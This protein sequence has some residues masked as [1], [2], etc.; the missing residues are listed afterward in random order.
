MDL[1]ATKARFTPRMKARQ[2]AFTLIELLVVIAIIAILAA[3]LLPVLEKAK[4]RAL[5]SQCLNNMKQLQVCYLMYVQDNNDWLPPNVSTSQQSTSTNSGSW[6]GGD[7]QTDVTIKNIQV[8]VLY[9]YN[10]SVVMYAC[11]ANTKKITVTGLGNIGPDGHPLNPGS[12]VPQTRTCSIDFLLN[13]MSGTPP[14]T[15]GTPL[16][17]NG[18]SVKPVTKY[19]GLATCGVSV[20][21]KIVFVDESEN[22]VG[23]GCFG[24]NV[25][26]SGLDSWW[27]LPGS[28]HTKGSTFAFA[29][30]HVEYWKWH[31]SDVISD[32]L[33]PLAQVE[34]GEL[35]ADPFPPASGSSDDLPRVQAATIP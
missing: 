23:D 28:R 13:G 31:G 20:A 32:N 21:N 2:S 27:N 34:A 30:G 22:S 35:P 14:Y 18:F 8:G 17:D 26:Q 3:I 15:P 6:I 12:L 7:A 1:F 5:T 11:P 4:Q 25:Q 9:Q 16:N 19:A 29:D 10:Q 33:L 24:I